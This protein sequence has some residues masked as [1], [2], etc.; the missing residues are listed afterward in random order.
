[1]NEIQNVISQLERQRD[2]IERALQ[3]L[4]E[5]GDAA[6]PAAPKG[7]A[8]AQKKRGR[9]RG[10]S[11]AGRARIGEATRKRWADKRAAETQAEK[12][13]ATSAK[14]PKKGGQVKRSMSPEGRARIAEAAKK[15]WAAK[16]AK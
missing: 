1:M 7:P 10:M 15:M 2:A 9:K 16:R 12:N 3:A 8:P 11:A 4:R 13:T 6:A 14:K 5:I